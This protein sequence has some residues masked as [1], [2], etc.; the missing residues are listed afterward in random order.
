[1]RVR[2][3]LLTSAVVLTMF[4]GSPPA[5][6]ALSCVQFPD[7]SH[8]AIAAGTPPYP[9]DPQFFE[10]WRHLLLGRVV[11]VT[12]DEGELSPTRGHT[13][14]TVEVAAALGEGNVPP[15]VDVTARDPGWL[16]GYAFT[17]G[18]AYAIPVWE[19]EDLG[20]WSS[21]TCDPITPL[22]DLDG[23]VDKVLAVAAESGT[24]IAAVVT[25][26]SGA[27]SDQA[28]AVEADPALA[29]GSEGGW[30][31]ASSAAVAAAVAGGGTLALWWRRRLQAGLP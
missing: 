26:G 13:R 18:D 16:N 31:W 17:V 2:R 21:F 12:T 19:I 7:D 1:M 5:A 6:T 22:D 9:G 23:A 20:Y 30:L 11:G 10:R 24:P 25:A 27:E 14:W 4:V 29:T 8:L 15:V 3:L 28:P